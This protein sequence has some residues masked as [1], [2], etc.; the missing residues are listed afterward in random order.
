MSGVI[1]HHGVNVAELNPF[2]GVLCELSEV[3]VRAVGVLSSPKPFVGLLK[4]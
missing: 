1:L 4:G 3:S 2:G